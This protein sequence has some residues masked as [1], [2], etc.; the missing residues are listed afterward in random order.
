MISLIILLC[1]SVLHRFITSFHQQTSK[2]FFPLLLTVRPFVTFPNPIVFVSLVPSSCP[3]LPKLSFPPP[4]LFRFRPTFLR[5]QIINWNSSSI[6]HLPLVQGSSSAFHLEELVQLFRLRP[7]SSRF[8]THQLEQFISLVPSSFF[9]I[10]R[11]NTTAGYT[12]VIDSAQKSD[13][14]LLSKTQTPI[15]LCPPRHHP[16]TIL[17]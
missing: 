2:S 16:T 6:S 12:N 14:C 4:E 11:I 5:F 9:H 1:L 13:F 7:T 15:I 8:S 17:S 3:R 10:G